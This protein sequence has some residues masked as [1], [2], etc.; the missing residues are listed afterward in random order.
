MPKPWPATRTIAT[1]SPYPGGNVVGVLSDNAALDEARKRLEQAGF[2]P[3][4]YDVLQGERD[5]ERIAEP[6]KS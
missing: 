4:R 1:D 6:P 5:V 2:G 3:D